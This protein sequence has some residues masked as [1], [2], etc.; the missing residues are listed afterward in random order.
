MKIL[1]RQRK[2]FLDRVATSLDAIDIRESDQQQSA[3]QSVIEECK[4]LHKI[5]PQPLLAAACTLE[6]AACLPV[7]PYQISC[8]SKLLNDWIWGVFNLQ[9]RFRHHA[10]IS[11]ALNQMQYVDDLFAS[12][13]PDL[14]SL[15]TPALRL[16]LCALSDSLWGLKFQMA[17]DE[18][19]NA[20]QSVPSLNE[21]LQ[22]V[23]ICWVSSS[24]LGR[25]SEFCK[26]NQQLQSLHE[27]RHSDEED[28]LS[29]QIHTSALL[30]CVASEDRSRGRAI[31]P[32]LMSLH[33]FIADSLEDDSNDAWLLRAADPE[34]PVVFRVHNLLSFSEE[35]QSIECPKSP[36]ITKK[37]RNSLGKMAS[38]EPSYEL[39][40][41][42]V[43]SNNQR[44]EGAALVSD[45]EQ[46]LYQAGHLW[47]MQ[48]PSELG[49]PMQGTLL[50]H[51]TSSKFR[52]IMCAAGFVSFNGRDIK[53]L[54]RLDLI[55]QETA[56][57]SVR[58][59]AGNYIVQQQADS[60]V[61]V[62]IKFKVSMEIAR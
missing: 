19:S 29:E 36:K 38:P 61:T 56:S 20:I 52:L 44:R 54:E 18:M 53:Q 58:K 8:V 43:A 59:F 13:L 45:S 2:F 26:W 47:F 32:D 24:I 7:A 21:D 3:V 55:E 12:P 41:R 11:H 27:L 57:K 28:S 30:H 37:I 50:R 10:S 23:A 31:L 60:D 39:V 6:L 51:R 4:R 22:S 15:P 9:S 16:A 5:Q 14:H 1:R 17:Y 49:L 33:A 40:S 48:S 25:W 34:E 46:K 62:D 35:M 42:S